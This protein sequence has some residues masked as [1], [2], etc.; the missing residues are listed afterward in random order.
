MS[1]CSHGIHSIGELHYQQREKRLTSLNKGGSVIETKIGNIQYGIPPETLKDALTQNVDVPEYYIVSAQTFDK[2]TGINLMEFEFPVYYNF[3]LRKMTKTKIICGS[4]TKQQIISIFQESLLG[5][6][7]FLDLDKDFADHYPARPD[8]KKELAHFAVNPFN[9]NQKLNPELFLEFLVFED[10][11]RLIEKEVVSED[12]SKE[13]VS[14]LIEKNQNNSVSVFENG[15]FLIKFDKDIILS[16][17]FYLSYQKLN[18]ETDI[19]FDPPVFG[20]TML[21]NS[22]GFDV[23][24]STSG[25]ILWINKRGIMIDPPPFASVALKQKGIPPNLIEKI[26]ISHCHADHD[27]GAF[28]KILE[29]TQIEFITTQTI[30]NSFLR[31][32]SAVSLMDIE[33]LKQLFEYRIVKIGHPTYI[34]GARFR[35][36]YAFHSIPCMRF[37]VEFN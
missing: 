10:N 20:V 16:K 9:R 18:F 26:I 35:F 7:D 17:E 37:E 2:Q 28:H 12:G 30:F 4:Q 27:A 14:I 11:K 25:F 21:G 6:K 19:Y 22:H 31:K 13:T 5:P 24:D 23:G 3:F 1:I 34:L 33:E 29:A 36:S 8:F 15:K 32:Y